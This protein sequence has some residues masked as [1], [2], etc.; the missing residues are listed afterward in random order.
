MEIEVCMK[1]GHRTRG[2]SLTFLKFDCFS[3]VFVKLKTFPILCPFDYRNIQD[4]M[5]HCSHHFIK[6][7]VH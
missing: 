2:V 1:C 3:Q 7:K 6:T 5:E 4:L